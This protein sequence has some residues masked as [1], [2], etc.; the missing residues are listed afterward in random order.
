V[1]REAVGHGKAGQKA[2]LG[3]GRHDCT[4]AHRGFSLSQPFRKE[5]PLRAWIDR[6]CPVPTILRAPSFP[7]AGSTRTGQ[8]FDGL[9][10]SGDMHSEGLLKMTSLNQRNVQDR[11]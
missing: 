7:L 4:V 10:V 11:G 9:T 5:P 1:A 2:A 8:R 3:R 6:S